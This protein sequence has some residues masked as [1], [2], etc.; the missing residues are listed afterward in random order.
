MKPQKESPE[1]W[2]AWP[3]WLRAM[4]I[5]MALLMLAGLMAVATSIPAPSRDIEIVGAPPMDFIAYVVAYRSQG[6][7]LVPSSGGMGSAERVC[8]GIG[9][10]AFGTI[11][12]ATDTVTF[13]REHAEL[14]LNGLPVPAADTGFHHDP[15]I[16]GVVDSAGQ[17]IGESMGT[18]GICFR[19]AAYPVGDYIGEITI[20]RTDNTTRFYDWAFSIR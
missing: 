2:R 9:I 18:I 13:V 3:R 7:L 5:V 1:G 14:K 10:E 8:L 6:L 11:P 4:L 19:T 17:T 12:E 20:T 16:V 15:T